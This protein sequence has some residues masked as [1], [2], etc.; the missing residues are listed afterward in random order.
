[1]GAITETLTAVY[2][3]LPESIPYNAAK[4]DSL[5]ALQQPAF[6]DIPRHPLGVRPSG[7]ALGADRNLS[8]STGTFQ[9]LPDELLL[10]LLQWLDEPELLNLGESCRAFYAYTTH[11][12]LW[13]DL[14]IDHT[15][16]QPLVWQGS[17]RASFLGR[18][19]RL[20]QVDCRNLFSDGL[21]RP[22]YC[23]QIPL[24]PYHSN[25]PD[26]NRIVRLPNLGPEEFARDWCDTP[27]VLTEAAKDWPVFKKWTRETLLSQ[28]GNLEFRAEAVD[29]PLMTYFDY[30]HTTEDE[31]PLY[32]F[33]R[34]F[35]RKMKLRVEVDRDFWP[36]DCFGED[37]FTLLGEQRPDHRWLIVG[38]PRSGSTFHKDPNATS[39]W[40]AVIEGS[41]Y[42]IMFPPGVLPPGVYIS[43]DQSEVTSP[44]SIAEWLLT[45]H[46]EA[47]TMVGCLEG[48]C[49]AGEVLHVPSGWWHLVVNLEAAVAITQNFVPESR[50]SAALD[51]L[52]QKPDQVSGFRKEVE[53]P[54]GLFIRRLQESRPN[55]VDGLQMVIQRKRKWQD[56]VHDEPEQ[57][58]EQGGF[59]FGFDDDIEEED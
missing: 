32:L 9:N 48:V 44:L 46:Q 45:F 12:Q 4:E 21:H 2:K 18:P 49:G 39:A 3:T 11:D 41:K 15:P 58:E 36:P 56:L 13:R 37:L 27:F 54:A 22:F 6:Q 40:N 43:E 24:S 53:D 47:R 51:F 5:D 14:W 35:V 50:L 23:S 59:A 30:M 57:V 38:P 55:L 20:A 26:R 28:Y 34:D 16:S 25:I 7:N 52:R 17:W 33:D 10:A 42:W 29:W 31:S 8:H 19:H 1:M